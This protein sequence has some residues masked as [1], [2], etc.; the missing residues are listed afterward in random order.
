MTTPTCMI[1][2]LLALLA[3]SAGAAPACHNITGTC[4]ERGFECVSG[5]VVP[6]AQRCNGVEDCSDGTDEFMCEHEDHRPVFERSVEERHAFAQASCVN[7]NCAATAFSV[8]STSAWWKYALT[9]P[10]DT[11]LMTG[12]PSQAAG[13]PCNWKC[14]SAITIGFYRKNRICRGWLCC[15][16]QRACTACSSSSPCTVSSTQNRCY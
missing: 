9:S 11:A 13:Q 5:E 14:A 3:V 2:A 8:L 1:A 6:H 10:T 4:T 7:C 15:A 12:T 16:R